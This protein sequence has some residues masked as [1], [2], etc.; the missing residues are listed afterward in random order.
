MVLKLEISRRAALFLKQEMEQYLLLK[1]LRDIG[2]PPEGRVFLIT[3][4][5]KA[6]TYYFLHF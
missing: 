5:N 2:M 1:I 3:V 4:A 6:R